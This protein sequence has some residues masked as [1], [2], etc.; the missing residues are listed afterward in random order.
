MGLP[1][2]KPQEFLENRVISPFRITEKEVVNKHELIGLIQWLGKF[3][4]P[5][6]C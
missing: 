6:A 1:C 2:L 4:A 3:R 5:K